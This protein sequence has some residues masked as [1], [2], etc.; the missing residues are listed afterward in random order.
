MDA[1]SLLRRLAVG[2]IRL[3][4]E[5]KEHYAYTVVAVNR[6]M[7]GPPYLVHLIFEER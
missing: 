5:I 4:R 2:E 1:L 6:I 7:I 3:L